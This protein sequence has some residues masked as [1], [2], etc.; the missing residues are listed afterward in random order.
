MHAPGDVEQLLRD[1]D[2][3][4]KWYIK[5]CQKNC[6]RLLRRTQIGRRILSGARSIHRTTIGTTPA[7]MDKARRQI[8]SGLNKDV[9]GAI[10]VVRVMQDQH[11]ALIDSAG[12]LSGQNTSSRGHA[13]MHQY[14]L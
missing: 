8:Y 9:D 2:G 3:E 6:H 14:S 1:N 13:R 5:A 11:S 4:T 7:A 12:P 10:H